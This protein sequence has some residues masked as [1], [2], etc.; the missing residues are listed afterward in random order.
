[1]FHIANNEAMLIHQNL[2]ANLRGLQ[3]QKREQPSAPARVAFFIRFILLKPPM[4]VQRDKR[5][6]L[7]CRWGV[8]AYWLRSILQIFSRQG[9]EVYCKLNE[10]KLNESFG[11]P[12]LGSPTSMTSATFSNLGTAC[13]TPLVIVMVSEDLCK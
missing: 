1:M 2:Q 7:S 11:S 13:S 4:R 3:I 8:L 10:C 6:P 12:H 9:A 5:R